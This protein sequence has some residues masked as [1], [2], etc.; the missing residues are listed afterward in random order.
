M[1]RHVKTQVELFAKGI[2]TRARL[3]RDLADD[4]DR[5]ANRAELIGDPDFKG[6]EFSRN[7]AWFASNVQNDVMN[8]LPNLRLGQL[9]TDAHDIDEQARTSEP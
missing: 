9:T 2:R 7:L 3:L 5:H 1:D 4:L 8:A 6:P